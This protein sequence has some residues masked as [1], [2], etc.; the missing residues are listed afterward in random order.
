MQCDFQ[1]LGK[2]PTAY[3]QRLSLWG[4]PPLKWTRGSL[5]SD[6]VGK[7]LVNDLGR[8]RNVHPRWSPLF[9][10]WHQAPHTYSRHRCSTNRT[11]LLY[12]LKQEHAHTSH[13]TNRNQRVSSMADQTEKSVDE[14]PISPIERRNSLEK[15]LQTRPDVKD[16]KDRHILLDTNAAP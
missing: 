6:K 7:Y 15:H 3:D 4:L 10:P 13:L 11:N 9:Q 8:R 12:I 2:K 16:L 5:E 1:A 14:T